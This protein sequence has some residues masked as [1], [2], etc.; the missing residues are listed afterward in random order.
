VPGRPR[1]ILLLLT[2]ALAAVALLLVACGGD[3]GGGGGSDAGQKGETAGGGGEECQRVEKPAP[4]QVRER[5]APSLRLSRDKTY[6]ATVETSCGTFAI[7]LDSKQAPRTGGSFVTLA[8]EGFYDGLTFHRIVADF[9]IQG[10]DPSGDGSGDAGYKVRERPPSDT[11]YSERFVAMAKAGDEPPGTSGSQFFV[12]TGV[13]AGLEPDYALLGRVT[14]GF[15]VVRKIGQLP[16]SQDPATAEQPL[17][18][19][20]IDN[21]KIGVK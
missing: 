1:S 10:G 13:D 14:R 11:V 4:R 2:A 9:V 21:V 17:E 8:R 7:Q 16:T 18:P 5:R 6:V 20:V 19:V 3:D 12:V 15:D